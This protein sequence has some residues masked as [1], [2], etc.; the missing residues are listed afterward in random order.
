MALLPP[1]VANAV[2]PLNGQRLRT[3]PFRLGLA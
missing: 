3:M 1:A 2:Y